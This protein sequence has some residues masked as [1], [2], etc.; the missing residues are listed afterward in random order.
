M[1]TENEQLIFKPARRLPGQLNAFPTYPWMFTWPMSAS[2]RSRITYGAPCERSR[3]YHPYKMDYQFRDRTTEGMVPLPFVDLRGGPANVH[4]VT[5]YKPE[6]AP[7]LEAVG[8]HRD[9]SVFQDG[10]RYNRM[11]AEDKRISRDWLAL[12]GKKYFYVKD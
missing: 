7:F 10:V 4:N 12:Y 6:P 1:A 3:S 8:I 9:F 11:M 5:A 2:E